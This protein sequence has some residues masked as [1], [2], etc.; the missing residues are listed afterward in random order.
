MKRGLIL[1]DVDL[2]TIPNSRGEARIVDKRI[3]R[4][5]VTQLLLVLAIIAFVCSQASSQTS[6]SPV[7]CGKATV[8][9]ERPQYLTFPGGIVAV[10]LPAGWALEKSK[11]DPFYFLRSGEK[12]SSARTL[13]YV[14]IERLDTSLQSA[15]KED[16]REFRESCPQSRVEEMSALDILEH[17]C[18]RFTQM[19]SCDRKQGAYVDLVTKIAIKGL[20]LNLVLSTDN[21]AEISR[22]RKDYEFVLKHLA[23]V[24]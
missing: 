16:V 1:T 24:R 21:A 7:D 13:M 6:T 14:H 20:L 3:G 19:F 5:G 8:H 18:E 10:E 12:Y 17:G 22:F 4:N 11:S 9:L 15:I 2:T 23:L